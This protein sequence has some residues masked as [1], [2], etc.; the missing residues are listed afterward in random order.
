MELDGRAAKIC[1][2]IE[3]AC[4]RARR[5]LGGYH[6]SVREWVELERGLEKLPVCRRAFGILLGVWEQGDY[7]HETMPIVDDIVTLFGYETTCQN[8]FCYGGEHCTLD[9]YSDLLDI[10]M[11]VK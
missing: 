1:R 6:R 4:P 2:M 11:G 10:T 8:C 3:T 9:D 5:N 7:E